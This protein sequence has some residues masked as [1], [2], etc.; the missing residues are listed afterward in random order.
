[1]E[2]ASDGRSLALYSELVT[3]CSN[4]ACM[5]QNKIGS[6]QDDIR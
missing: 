3:L 5:D 6:E 2:T 4:C 1:M